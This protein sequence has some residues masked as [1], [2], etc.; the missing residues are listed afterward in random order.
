[1]AGGGQHAD[2][3]HG[4]GAADGSDQLPD[5]KGSAMRIELDEPELRQ[6]LAIL[7]NA[8]WA[9]ANPLIM[10]IAQQMQAA[11]PAQGVPAPRPDG[12]DKRQSQ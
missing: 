11:P 6:V 5:E 7:S 9:Q 4:S 2:A 8:P 10:K 12:E 3:V 1:M